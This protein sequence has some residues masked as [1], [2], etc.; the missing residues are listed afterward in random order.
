MRAYH[1]LSAKNAL[2]D[3][4]R[5]QIRLSEIDRLNDPFELWCSAQDDRR[6]RASLRAWKD[7]MGRQYGMLCFSRSWHSTVLW[8]HYSDKHRGMCLG[9]EVDD[10]CIK[11]VTY[12]K[13]RT[14]LRPPFTRETMERLLFTKYYDWSYEEE[15]RGW[16]RLEKRDST[17]NY[18]YSFDDKVRL[19]EVIVG[20]LCDIPRVTIDALLDDFKGAIRV[21]KSRLAFRSF[22]V[23]QNLRGFRR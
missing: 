14:D 4:R 12:V 9:F 5:K 6:I 22:R 11:A 7:E 13:E 8:S 3:L 1:F 2:D 16:F 20:P 19:S 15:L 23:V 21:T 10:Q 18:F 17:G